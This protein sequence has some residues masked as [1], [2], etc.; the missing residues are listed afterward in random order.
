MNS[1]GALRVTAGANAILDR[2]GL[3]RNPY[4][5]ALADGS[6]PLEKFRAGQEQFFFAVRY[7]SRPMAALIARMPDPAQHLDILHNIVEEH[8]EFTPAHF[9]QNTFR[10]FLARIGARDPIAGEVEMGP[11]VHA[12][13]NTLMAA[14]ATDEIPVGVCCLGII[15]HAFATL[16]ATIGQSVVRRG[17]VSQGD[18]VHYTLHAELDVRHAEEFFAL[19]EGQWEDANGRRLIDQGLRLGAYAFDQLYR[20]M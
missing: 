18:M 2:V 8:G 3:M 15:E 19:V 6:M 13:N 7:F 1:Q 11:A 17:W 20:N 10:Q 14:C 16:S 4:F 12:F 9:H 5:T